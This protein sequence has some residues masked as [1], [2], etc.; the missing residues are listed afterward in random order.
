MGLWDR[1][2]KDIQK[3]VD[4]G[5]AAVRKGAAV[6][7]EKAEELAEEGKRRYKVFELKM[8]VQSN[9]TEL[10]G[11]VYDLA[12]KGSKNPLLDAKVLSAINGVKKLEAQ[13]AKLEKAAGAS[14]KKVKKKLKRK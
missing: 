13:I 7:V 5:I 10:G 4:E 11:K 14:P 1:V 8:K 3:G 6:A 9:F 2:K 12:S